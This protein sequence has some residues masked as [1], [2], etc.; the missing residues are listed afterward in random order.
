MAPDGGADRGAGGTDAQTASNQGDGVLPSLETGETA[1]ECKAQIA[2]RDHEDSYRFGDEGLTGE[3]RHDQQA[4]GRRSG[5]PHKASLDKIEKYVKPAVVA[6]VVA[7]AEGEAAPAAA[8][9][10]AAPAPA[11]E[12]VRTLEMARQR[13]DWLFTFEAARATHLDAGDEEDLVLR[14]EKRKQKE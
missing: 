4:N 11:P 8:G 7:A 12:P 6:P 2:E 14:F 10:E 5:G 3:T 1:G 13:G 9:G